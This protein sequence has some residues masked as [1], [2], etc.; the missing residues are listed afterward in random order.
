MASLLLPNNHLQSYC[1]G[2]NAVEYI[3]L[4]GVPIGPILSA[5]LQNTVSGTM[6]LNN[7]VVSNGTSNQNIHSSSNLLVNDTLNTVSIPNALELPYVPV[8][9]VMYV[10]S[11][12]FVQSTDLTDGQFLIGET[13]ADPQVGTLT[14]TDSSVSISYATPNI[15]LSVP[16]VANALSNSVAG[17]MT[18]G[19]VVIANGLSHV[20]SHASA[21][22]VINDTLQ[23]VHVAKT[24][25]MDSGTANSA[26]ITGA[27]KQVQYVP[28]TNGQLLI[29][30]TG[31]A[32]MASNISAGAGINIVNGPGNITIS[33]AASSI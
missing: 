32:P 19:Q 14:S 17:N 13:L 3:K 22:L 2:L 20:L 31:A 25:V 15:N 4:G 9:S 33:S 11:L 28:L 12:G 10:D 29:G 16:S 6:G 1:K 30:N 5:S 23:E 7:V 21:Q 24:L 27:T 26:L 18:A 8:S